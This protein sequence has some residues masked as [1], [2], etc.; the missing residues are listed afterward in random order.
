M[1][2]VF[3]LK[4]SDSIQ[5]YLLFI[6]LFLT[7]WDIFVRWIQTVYFQMTTAA[8]EEEAPLEESFCEFEGFLFICENHQNHLLIPP[9]TLL[10]VM[11]AFCA[12]A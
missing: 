9:L 7:V 11:S 3:A 1:I 6:L 8:T 2:T 4:V 10:W 5:W 12:C